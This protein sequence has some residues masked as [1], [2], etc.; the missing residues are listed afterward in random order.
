MHTNM[1]QSYP[2]SHM[3][4]PALRRFTTRRPRLFT[5]LVKMD[6]NQN[7]TEQHGE[8]E[9]N[10]HDVFHTTAELDGLLRDW[11]WKPPGKELV[12]GVEEGL[13]GFWNFWD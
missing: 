5:V 1:S 2:A 8:D 10:L 9:E 12:T 6:P 7:A 4:T 11:D 3:K 13:M